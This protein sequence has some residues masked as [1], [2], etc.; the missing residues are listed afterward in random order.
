MRAYS[1]RL[2]R[3]KLYS[4]FY[5]QFSNGNISFHVGDYFDNDDDDDVREEV[6]DMN[7]GRNG[8]NGVI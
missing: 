4:I 1:D 8:S 6:A 5:G 7:G 2:Y 3:L